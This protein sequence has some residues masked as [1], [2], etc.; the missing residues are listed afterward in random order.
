MPIIFT[1]HR[2]FSVIISSHIGNP[3]QFASVDRQT[4]VIGI[5]WCFHQYSMGRRKK[6]RATESSCQQSISPVTMSRAS[7]P[8]STQ[9]P[10]RDK[11][12]TEASFQEMHDSLEDAKL[13]PTCSS[14]TGHAPVPHTEFA[15]SH[16]SQQPISL[17]GHAPV[18]HVGQQH[19]SL[20]GHA[21]VSHVGQQHSSLTGHT[22]VSHVGQQ[23]SSLTSVL[24]KCQFCQFYW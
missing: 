3:S 12:T 20:T 13:G 15:E 19:N 24:E 1:T 2:S 22:P 8:D 4:D 16:F 17:T 5:D 10:G 18:S 23:H 6:N 7:S 9:Q 11:M 14:L 21:P